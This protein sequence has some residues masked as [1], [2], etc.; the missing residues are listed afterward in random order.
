MTGPKDSNPTNP[1]RPRYQRK[2]TVGDDAE[3]KAD[4]IIDGGAGDENNA[5]T[6][7]SQSKLNWRD[8]HQR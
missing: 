1:K 3:I 5:K 8:F 6:K 2:S 4:A 7:M